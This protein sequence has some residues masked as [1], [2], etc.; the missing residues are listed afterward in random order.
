M[1]DR[2]SLQVSEGIAHVRLNRPDKLNALDPA[3]IQALHAAGEQLASDRG[4][5]V[6]VLSGEG[7]AFCAGLDFT[8]FMRM[9]G[10]DVESQ[11][12]VNMTARTDASPANYIQDACWLWHRLPVPVIAAVH[13]AAFG[14][15]LQLALG[16][17][18]RYARPDARLSIMEIKWGLIPDMSGTQ[19]LRHLVRQ[20]IAKELTFTGR[21][22]EGTEAAELGLVTRVYDDPL[23]AALETART[24]ASKSPDAIRA[25]KRLWNTVMEGTTEDNLVLEERLQVSLVGQPNNREAIQANLENRPPQFKDPDA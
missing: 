6:V 14:G 8:G 9:A 7:R 22:I 5:R 19:A 1:T 25:G 10:Q 21:Q 11:K 18:M 13:G 16:A 4:V 24:I 12:N 3:M 15:G 20:D 2:V 23:T 17:D